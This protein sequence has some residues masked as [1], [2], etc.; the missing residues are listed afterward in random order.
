[1]Q[2]MAQSDCG[3]E[4]N[5]Y[6][7]AVASSSSYFVLAGVTDGVMQPWSSSGGFQGN[8]NC[9]YCSCTDDAWVAVFDS[10]KTL[11]WG[12]QYSSPTNIYQS[13]S[14]FYERFTAVAVNGDQVWA[15]GYTF[16]D[17]FGTSA[18]G[19][20]VIRVAFYI[21][22]GSEIN[23]WQEGTSGDDRAL[24]MEFNS[25]GEHFVGGETT[26]SWGNANGGDLDICL[27]KYG[28]SGTQEWAVTYGGS[29]EDGFA[30][31][32]ISSAGD[33]YIAGNTKGSLEGSHAGGTYDYFL[34][35]FRSSDGQREWL[36]GKKK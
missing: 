3:V 17:L 36:L 1:M 15:A 9:E 28:Q 8:Y 33:I 22:S 13:D 5:A 21:A 30:A 10:S 29:A 25:N 6:S 18:G 14:S 34:V 32:K 26:G 4:R 19:E 7:L 23:K 20:D 27:I 11:L 31:M 12:K 2:L 35:K 24:G 16:Q